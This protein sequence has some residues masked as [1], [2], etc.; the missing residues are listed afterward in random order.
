[1]RALEVKAAG[2]VKSF[3]DMKRSNEEVAILEPKKLETGPLQ[4]AVY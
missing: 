3:N 2:L 4:N 1:V